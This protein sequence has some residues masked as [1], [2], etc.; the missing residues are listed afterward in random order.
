MNSITQRILLPF[1][2]AIAGLVGAS[3]SLL[4]SRGHT[5]YWED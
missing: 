2:I 4:A 1:D 3:A 5:R